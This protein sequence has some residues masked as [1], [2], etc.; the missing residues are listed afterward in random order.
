[1][2]EGLTQ[3]VVPTTRSCTSSG[4][5]CVGLVFIVYVFIVL[6]LFLFQLKILKLRNCCLMREFFPR[7]IQYFEA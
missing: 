1:M 5:L 3:I 6:A 7:I 4:L 2:V